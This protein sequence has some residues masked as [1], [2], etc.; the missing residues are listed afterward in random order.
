MIMYD[1]DFKQRKIKFAPRNTYIYIYEP[2]KYD[3]LCSL[4]ESQ[5]VKK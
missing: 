5:E 1:N 4:W 3:P 2:C